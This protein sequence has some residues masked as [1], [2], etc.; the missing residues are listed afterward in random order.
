MSISSFHA[1]TNTE[2]NAVTFHVYSPQDIQGHK[3]LTTVSPC[4]K[5]WEMRI[6]MKM[7]H[8]FENWIVSFEMQCSLVLSLDTSLT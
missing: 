3:S 7:H 4:A 8:V 1:A 6:A 5:V 2:D